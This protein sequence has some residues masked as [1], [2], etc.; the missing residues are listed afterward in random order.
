METELTKFVF[1]F[2]FVLFC[3]FNQCAKDTELLG[4]QMLPEWTV[5]K[6]GT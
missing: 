6:K 5:A 1:V 3:F 2:G 4:Q